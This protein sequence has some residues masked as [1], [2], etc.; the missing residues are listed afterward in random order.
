MQQIALLDPT[1]G[2]KVFKPVD[3]KRVSIEFLTG[4]L[5]KKGPKE[6]YEDTYKNKRL[7]H[8]ERMLEVIDNDV[9]E[10]SNETLDKNWSKLKSKP[11]KKYDFLVKG[12]DGLKAAVFNLFK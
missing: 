9:I 3:I 6:G 1:T 2:F 7:L 12:G 4:L 5:M 8:K 10:L 11:G